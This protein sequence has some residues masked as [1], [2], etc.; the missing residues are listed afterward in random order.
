MGVG[1][2]LCEVDACAFQESDQCVELL[3]LSEL[4][5]AAFVSA[6]DDSG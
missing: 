5:N 2:D 4:P 3:R 1:I 6:I